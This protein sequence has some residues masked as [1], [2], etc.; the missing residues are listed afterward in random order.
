MQ[1]PGAAI[2]RSGPEDLPGLKSRP[3]PLWV[4]DQKP[5]S[6]SG[7]FAAER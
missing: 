2:V 7:R 5:Q 3:K 4:N 1:E 6:P